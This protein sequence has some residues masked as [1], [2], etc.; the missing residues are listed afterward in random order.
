MVLSYKAIDK[1]LA[2]KMVLQ[3]YRVILY[4]MSDTHL[5]EIDLRN[6]Y[7]G[8]WLSF[9]STYFSE[10]KGLGIPQKLICKIQQ[11]NTN[12]IQPQYGI[13]VGLITKDNKYSKIS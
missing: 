7:F 3:D 5:A 10:T 8:K 9:H 1:R 6:V 4:C 11:D 2:R 12:H 13:Q